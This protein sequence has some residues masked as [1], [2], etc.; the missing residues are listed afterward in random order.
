MSDNCLVD[1][2]NDM[3]IEQDL[4]GLCTEI[5]PL[6]SYDACQ[7]VSVKV[8]DVSDNEEETVP[9]PVSWHSVKAECEVSCMS[10]GC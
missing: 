6:S 4:P 1:L 9:M 3:D 2:Q 10:L 5:C 7:L 8:E